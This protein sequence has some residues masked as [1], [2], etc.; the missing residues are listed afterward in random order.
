MKLEYS[1]EVK[2][3]SDKV[4][5]EVILVQDNLKLMI[6]FS[7]LMKFRDV[8][9]PYCKKGF[10]TSDDLWNAVSGLD[11]VPV[12]GKCFEVNEEPLIPAILESGC[13]CCGNVMS[14]TFG[15]PH[16]LHSRL[17]KDNSNWICSKCYEATNC[18]LD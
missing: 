11:N 12:H 2:F 16:R 3:S 18:E 9:C 5:T 10:E 15:D 1:S 8:A 17:S 14:S 13:S 4:P 7:F 6:E